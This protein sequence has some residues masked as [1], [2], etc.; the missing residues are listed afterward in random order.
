VKPYLN[1]PLISKGHGAAF[2]AEMTL[3]FTLEKLA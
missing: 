1:F 3:P 2:G